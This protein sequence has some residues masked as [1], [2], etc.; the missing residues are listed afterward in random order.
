MKS[1]ALKP[2]QG[3]PI[4]IVGL[5]LGNM[6]I[7]GVTVYF[8][9]R[10]RTSDVVPDYYAKALHWDDT[11]RQHAAN[12]ALGWTLD[13]S[14]A[15]VDDATS[16]VRLRLTDGAGDPIRAATIDLEAFH[17]ADPGARHT[18][19]LVSRHD[20]T[21]EGVLESSRPGRWRVHAIADAVGMR[22]TSEQQVDFGI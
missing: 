9:A 5:L 15:S 6:A 13:V 21:Y 10:T 12:R 8:A 18:I 20:G 1:L 17:Q 22:F 3:W 7:V 2:G 11:A 4:A 14:F 16:R 19:T